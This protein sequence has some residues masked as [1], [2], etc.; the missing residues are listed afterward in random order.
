[1]VILLILGGS[2][3]WSE[4]AD[5]SWG[6]RTRVFRDT[7]S[8]ILRC[9]DETSEVYARAVRS[10]ISGGRPGPCNGRGLAPQGSEPCNQGLLKG[11]LL[12]SWPCHHETDASPEALGC[13][14]R[15]LVPRPPSRLVPP[16]CG[17]GRS[18]IVDPERW[19]PMAAP[20]L[21]A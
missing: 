15:S 11:G 5:V 7:G 19:P 21:E 6:F 4:A 1:M 16:R 9:S 10:D 8:S 14:S 3:K 12:P 18:P 17:T 20:L 2:E 13:S